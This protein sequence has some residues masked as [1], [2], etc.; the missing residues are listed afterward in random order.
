VWNLACYRGEKFSAFLAISGTFW[1]PQPEVCPSPPQNLIQIHGVADRTVPLEGRAIR[2]GEF[3]Q[4]DVFRAMGMMRRANACPAEAGRGHR[5]GALICE[6]ITGCVS[7]KVL[8]LCL[9]PGGHD[10]DASWLD[11]A[12]MRFSGAK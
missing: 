3:R 11:F 5:E 1:T 9:H 8:D 6:R 2:N 10:F 7:G 4:G 12:W